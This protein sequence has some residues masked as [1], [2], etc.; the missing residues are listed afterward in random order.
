MSPGI[1]LAI[2]HSMALVGLSPQPVRV[3]VRSGRGTAEF[4]VVGLP[5]ATVRESKIRVRTAL[6]EVGVP[7]HSHFIVVNLAPADLRKV[8][9][10]FDLAIAM[11]SVAAIGELDAERLA[12]TLL[13]GEV[14]LS[15]ELLPI[16]GVLPRLTGAAAS[17]FTRAI[18]PRANSAEGFVVANIEG[19]EVFV[20]DTVPEVIA[21]LKGDGALEAA[22]PGADA[23]ASYVPDLSDVLGQDSARQ[24]LT[25]AAAGGHN[26]LFMGP[27]GT[28]KTMLAA[29][30]PG[31]LPP[32]ED[33]EALVVTAL[34]S[35]AG[36]LGE[37]LIRTRPYR[38]PHHSVSPAGLLGAGDP[39]R[40]GEVS[41]AHEGVLFLDELPEF[42]RCAIEGL[43]QPLEDG[44]IRIARAK[45]SAAF[46]ARPLLVAAMNPCPCGYFGTSQARRCE[47]SPT[48]VLDYRERISGPILDRI[49]IHAQLTPVSV[50]ALMDEAPRAESTAVVRARVIAARE[51]QRAR[52]LRGETSAP[53]N[54]R[55]TSR[56]LL[57]VVKLTRSSRD[58][59]ARIMNKRNLSARAYHKV[60]RVART[61]ADLEGS[62]TVEYMHIANAIN[63]R[64]LDSSLG[65]RAA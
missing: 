49:D 56:D 32:L 33:D 37:G 3:E 38:A 48:R 52:H 54:A 28:G 63:F 21:F 19:L 23:Q 16:R 64:I 4:I 46:P 53:L 2:A 34:H 9:S 26:L 36:T 24:V 44:V 6:A 40:P 5:E 27:P 45:S 10:A 47:C 18:I 39:P 60:L 7:L 55:L 22:L 61:V 17:G 12:R 43:R 41:L 59:L 29:R 13:L 30:M 8:G 31:I 62:P 50:E 11:G 42:Q 20:A 14:S 1:M 15:G 35:I 57:R 58:Q 25:I 51:L 65:E